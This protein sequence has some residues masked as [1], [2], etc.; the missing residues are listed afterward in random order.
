MNSALD[1]SGY[2]LVET[3]IA[4]TLFVA[5]LLPITTSMGNLFIDRTPERM[6]EALQ[7]AEK[8]MTEISL[9][10]NYADGVGKIVDKF[11]ISRTIKRNNIVVDVE[12]MVALTEKRE[13]PI[14]ILCKSFLVY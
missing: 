12:V 14:V 13:K 5:V 11:I 7:V 9:Q 10:K 4:M 2:T 3:V 1:E 8:E 6:S